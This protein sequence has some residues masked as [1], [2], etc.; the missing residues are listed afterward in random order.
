M[1]AERPVTFA[2]LFRIGEYRALWSSTLISSVGDQLARVALALLVFDRSGSPFLTAL[3]YALTMLP[4]LLG[5]PLLGGL[6][7]RYPRRDL[8]IACNLIRTALGAAMALPTMPLAVLCVLVFA[9]QLVDSPERAARTALIRDVLPDDL[10]SLGVTANQL[11]YQ[12]TLLTGFTVGA[13][14]VSTIGPYPALAANAATFACCA[15]IVWAGV[16]RRPAAE[17]SPTRRRTG[18]AEGVRLIMGSA[19]LR[20][21]LALALLAGFY[22]VPGGLAVPYAAQIHTPPQLIGLLLGAIPA[23]NVVGMLLIG[24]VLPHAAQ[25]RTLGPLAAVAGLPLTVCALHPGLIASVALWSLTGVAAAYQVIAQAEFVRALPSHR[26]GQALGL[27][28]P[29][30]TAVQ[31]VGLLLGGVLADHIGPATTIA[32][33]GAAGVVTGIPLALVWRRVRTTTTLS[34]AVPQDRMDA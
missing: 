4:A 26:R 2:A 5:G 14:V 10:Y 33:T 18:T 31:G 11:T 19:W 8:I 24:R 27:A 28:V 7:D 34:P 17:P 22:V 13:V 30:I 29:A 32:V 25:V 3:T 23:G 20:S 9:L 16:R 1:R 6:A 15:L 12:V 21:V